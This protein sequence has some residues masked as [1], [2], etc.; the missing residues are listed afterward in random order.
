MRFDA[1]TQEQRRVSRSRRQLPQDLTTLDDNRSQ[2]DGT[3]GWPREAKGQ[4]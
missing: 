3:T 2:A 1:G 4:G